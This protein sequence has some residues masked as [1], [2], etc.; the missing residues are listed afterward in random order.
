MTDM[1]QG[2]NLN[3]DF[4]EAYRRVNA[5]ILQKI[6]RRFH[7]TFYLVSE[8]AYSVVGQ[9]GQSLSQGR[10]QRRYPKRKDE[11]GTYI[12]VHGRVKVYS[13]DWVRPLSK[14]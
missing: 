9:T 1:D 5:F 12:I 4:D 8:N 10:P 11:R 3:R 7:P 6:E 14:R 13:R 2:E